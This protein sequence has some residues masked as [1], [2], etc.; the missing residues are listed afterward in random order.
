MTSGASHP[1]GKAKRVKSAAK[2]RRTTSSKQ[3]VEV[4]EAVPDLSKRRDHQSDLKNYL[5]LWG[6]RDNNSGW[7]FNKV[8]QTWALLNALDKNAID[9]DLFKELCPYLKS[10]SGGAKDRFVSVIEGIIQ[11]GE[12]PP[13]VG[14]EGGDGIE[15]PSK[16]K[17]KRAM[18][19]RKLLLEEE[20][21]RGDED[22]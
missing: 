17:L 14:P 3:S 6:N 19:L 11:D 16:A 1:P 2:R 10:I 8:L 18:K 15:A 20:G 4:K 9:K 13:A 22:S 7:K 21:E 12:T 5:E